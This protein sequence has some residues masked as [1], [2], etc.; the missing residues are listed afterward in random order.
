MQGSVF[1][2]QASVDDIR[3]APATEPLEAPL[4]RRTTA[5]SI[6]LR[7]VHAFRAREAGSRFSRRYHTSKLLEVV[8]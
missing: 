6:L 3:L 4:R 8:S 7:W 2:N 5:A 1:W